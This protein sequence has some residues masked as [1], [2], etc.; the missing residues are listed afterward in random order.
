MLAFSLAAVTSAYAVPE[1]PS[2]DNPALKEYQKLLENYLYLDKQKAGHIVCNVSVPKQQ[3]N[4][5]SEIIYDSSEKKQFLDVNLVDENFDK[6]SV[7][8]DRT[9]GFSFNSHIKSVLKLA[10]SE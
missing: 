10:S 3:G 9:K 8:Y 6:F 7:T 4:P 5:V 1:T 2:G